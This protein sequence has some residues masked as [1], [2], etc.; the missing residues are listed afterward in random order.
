MRNLKKN[1]FIAVLGIVALVLGLHTSI[2]AQTSSADKVPVTVQ[3]FN[4]AESDMYFAS[5]VKRGALGKFV[6]NREPTP[7][8]K[9]DVVGMNRDTF[10]SGGVFDLD[11][12]PVTITL[13]TTG[14]RFMSLLI[15]NEDAYSPEVVY[16][17]G[18]YTFT[19]EKIETR[20]MLAVVRTLV[21][22][23]SPKDIEAVHKIQDSIKVEQAGAGKFEIPN[24]DPV[25]QKKI[26][27]ALM[28]LAGLQGDN[29][30]PKF[31][32]KGEVDPIFHLI[33]TGTGWGGNP[34]DA[35]KYINV[36]PKQNDGKTVYKLT[37]KDVPVDGFWSISV[38]NADR[39]FV[40]NDL[41]SYSINNI[42]GKPNADGS[43]TLQFGACQKDTPNCIPTPPDWNYIVRM[44]RPR[45]EVLDGTWKFPEAQP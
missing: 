38:Y 9:Q 25:P 40:K 18:S 8:E 28:V 2:V 12:G 24:W 45:K 17:P 14:K 4:R 3:N 31:G 29:V 43:F 7:I 6:H 34:M 11:A 15:V 10:Y 44:Y 42:T 37:L 32:W 5:T 41:D 20:Y 36:Y 19:K 26:R 39:Y 27:E 30:P 35:A 22:P 23:E 1:H 16:A 13:P 33:S 21:D